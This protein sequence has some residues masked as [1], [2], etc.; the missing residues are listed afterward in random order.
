VVGR[1]GLDVNGFRRDCRYRRC[2]HS[3]DRPLR[4]NYP[5]AV[6]HLLDSSQASRRRRRRCFRS[7][8]SCAR[9]GSTR[10]SAAV[11]QR[12]ALGRVPPW[13]RHTFVP[14]IARW[15]Q[16]PVPVF[17]RAVHWL[18]LRSVHEVGTPRGDTRWGCR[19]AIVEE[20]RNVNRGFVPP[21]AV[22][23]LLTNCP[24]QPISR[25]L[26]G[27]SNKASLGG[28]AA[29]DSPFRTRTLLI[30]VC[31]TARRPSFPLGTK[32]PRSGARTGYSLLC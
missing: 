25:R 28:S 11:R 22:H 10:R 32:R 16:R 6:Q 3:P 23:H 27:S 1:N 2:R 26:C 18:A 5:D 20:R 17:E 30:R 15:R 14:R 21:W 12:H 4:R 24:T 13:K 31:A 29:A 19:D 8:A 9:A 7:F